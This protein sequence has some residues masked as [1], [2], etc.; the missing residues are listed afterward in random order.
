MQSDKD[1]TTLGPAGQEQLRLNEKLAEALPAASREDIDQLQRRLQ[2]LPRDAVEQ[3]VEQL[4]TAPAEN[5]DAVD[6]VGAVPERLETS[7]A[8]A[9][10]SVAAAASRPVPPVSPSP[11][12]GSGGAAAPAEVTPEEVRR[13]ARWLL[14]RADELE[15]R[16]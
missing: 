4:R 16:G 2:P 12:A 13:V 11:S 5:L 9:G 6:A 3:T 7:G 14:E 1:P 15:A 10:G 8:A